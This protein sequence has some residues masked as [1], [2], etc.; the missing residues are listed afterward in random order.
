MNHSSRSS[1][2]LLTTAALL[3]VA[4]ASV[5]AIQWY[6]PDLPQRVLAYTNTQQNSA[7]GDGEG[8][9]HQSKV[10]YSKVTDPTFQALVSKVEYGGRPP[11][12]GF[13]WQL[14]K[15]R[16]NYTEYDKWNGSSWVRVK[17]LGAGDWL[18]SGSP[19]NLDYHM[20]H[21]DVILPGGALVTQTIGHKAS[22]CFV[23]DFNIV[24]YNQ[25]YL[26]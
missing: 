7:V 25:H 12:F 2:V 14:E 24:A 15:W 13:C 9:S 21:D 4:L 1:R 18:D 23:D 11:D 6:S 26:E 17:K 10:W 8:V 19:G 5:V 3:V 20:K 22:H 16:H